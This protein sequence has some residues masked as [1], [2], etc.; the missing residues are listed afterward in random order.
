MDKVAL[1][2]LISDYKTSHH[3]ENKTDAEVI[4]IMR[5]DPKVNKEDIKK[6]SFLIAGTAYTQ[7]IGDNLFLKYKKTDA[8]VSVLEVKTKDGK[9]YNFNETL[10][11]RIEN[12]SVLLKKS[13]KQNGLIG[14]AWSGL[15]NVFAFGDSS[16][17]VRDIISQEKKLLVK[18]NSNEKA[19]AG[20]FKELTGCEYTPENLEKFITGEIK[21]KSEIAL[22]KYNE[23]QEMAVDIT[24]DIV[25][26]VIS[27]GA[28]AL[29]IA[30]G[31][32]AAP[33]TAG[34][35]LG[36]VAVGIGIAAT[37]GAVT[38]VAVKGGEA[39]VGGKEYS[40]KDA[41]KDAAIGGVAGALAPLTMGTG[42]AVATSVGKVAPKLATTA[43]FAVEGG[44]FG[45]AD[46]GT[47][48]ALE[49]DSAG[50]VALNALK[51][52]GVGILAGNILGH[53]GST[54]G[55][56]AQYVYEKL[57]PVYRGNGF[58]YRINPFGKKYK[59]KMDKPTLEKIKFNL[60]NKRTAN[61]HPTNLTNELER[62]LYGK[63]GVERLLQENPN[64]S[65]VVGSLPQK[66]GKA[67]S[68]KEGLYKIDEIFYN[69]SKKYH[70]GILN[71][72][73]IKFAQQQLSNLLGSEVEMA[74]L[75]QGQI[76]RTFVIKVDGQRFVLKCYHNSINHSLNAHGNY[77]ELSSAVY[78][79]RNDR[80]HFAKFYMGR[81]GENNDGY[82]LTK[83]I[84]DKPSEKAF[85]LS[86]YIKS[87]STTD[88]GH[89]E[90]GNTII[91]YGQVY[92][93]K[94]LTKFNNNERKI[95]RQLTN[96]IDNNHPDEV[97]QII[98]KYG[99]SNDFINPVKYLKALVH[100]LSFWQTGGF[101]INESPT[102]AADYF[103]ER[104]S[105]LKQ[106][107]I[108]CIPSLNNANEIIV[109]GVES[110]GHL[111]YTKTVP[112]WAES[113]K[114]YDLTFEEWSKLFNY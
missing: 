77:A 79:S 43:R 17:K 89:N 74:V 82:I 22:E 102:M 54:I 66:W 106:L 71:A 45:F 16:D 85:R 62:I 1:Q 75:G 59:L 39:L 90:F 113:G 4:S 49:G 38:K 105:C 48:S 84:E 14:K 91:D 47:R 112:Y 107:N 23:G 19:R 44:M 50:E 109:D 97:A 111:S 61:P 70:A 37:A 12:T 73:D 31:I 114:Y 36:A 76:G 11:N 10:S 55:K 30:G 13:E 15:K 18:F 67:L 100:N 5:N 108:D 56:G 93:D 81:F 46:G 9:T 26:G 80:K 24:S 101:K 3:L 34:A 28:A 98:Q 110:F 103:I 94:I 78:A 57:T 88:G 6:L 53:G 99:D 95:L 40:L 27:Y 64:L 86:R 83:F 21:L 63:T 51:G 65:P 42:G 92:S 33:F 8:P 2:K 60:K 32:A 29:C 41:G 96:A 7:P 87:M 58:S 25:A 52:A 68:S 69:F 35:S 20:A 104:V 72:E